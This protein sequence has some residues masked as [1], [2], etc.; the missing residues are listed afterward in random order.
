MSNPTLGVGSITGHV[1]TAVERFRLV[2]LG[3]AGIS[4]AAPGDLIHGVVTEP[5]A[6]GDDTM[7][8]RVVAV[9]RYGVVPIE[10]AGDADAIAVGTVVS[11]AADG[12]VAAGAGEPV[13]YVVGR[14]GGPLEAVLVDL[15][16]TIATVTTP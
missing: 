16:L 11:V 3:P 13:G 14:K 5:G 2:T 1:E 8:P 4:H 12:K 7:P 10:V 6:P 15:R 9:H